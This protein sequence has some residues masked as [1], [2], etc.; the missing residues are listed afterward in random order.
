MQE[1]LRMNKRRQATMLKLVLIT[2]K[3]YQ[4]VISPY[5]P[6]TCRYTPTCSEYFYD[7]TSK[8]GILKGSLLGLKRLV[9]CNPLGGNGFDPVP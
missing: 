1:F 6:V 9:K 8:K 3:F 2:V 4:K 5:L 7:A